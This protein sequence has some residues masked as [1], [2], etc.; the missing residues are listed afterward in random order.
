MP[1]WFGYLFLAAKGTYGT[2]DVQDYNVNVNSDI[3]VNFRIL[4]T[5]SPIDLFDTE[6]K[7]GPSSSLWFRRYAPGMTS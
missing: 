5:F 6:L 3:D 2:L 4:K 7:L 1:D